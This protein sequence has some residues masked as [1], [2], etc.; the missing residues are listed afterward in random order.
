[1]PLG[2]RLFG[3]T[4]QYISGT[5]V[6]VLTSAVSQRHV[7]EVHRFGFFRLLCGHSRRLLTRMLLPFVVC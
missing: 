2:K 4:A 6:H 5:E 1:M 3:A 7:G